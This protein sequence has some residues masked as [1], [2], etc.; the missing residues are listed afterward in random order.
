[1]PAYNEAGRIEDTI[2]RW[3][4][5]LDALGPAYE[6]VVVDDGSTDGTGDALDALARRHRVVRVIHQVNRGHG[7]AVVAGYHAA[8]GSWVLQVDA[9]D[10]V[11]P[12]PFGAFW[13]ERESWDLQLG[14]RRSRRQ[15]ASRALLS[16]ALGWLVGLLASRRLRDA[17]SPY[18]LHRRS[19][20][21]SLLAVLPPDVF[22]PNAIVSALA[23]ARRLRIGEREVPA[24]G[25]R[26]S[27]SLGGL[28]LLRAA[29]RS[30]ADLVAAVAAERCRRHRPP[31]R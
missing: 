13:Q 28:R 9:D 30:L 18:R 15:R 24:G 7:P 27:R 2:A 4:E 12:A 31:T 23:V 3:L 11:G 22:A 8:R 5:A 6:V 25:G 17:N 26:E 20:L 29:G 21:E 10:E 16:L 14:V 1:V 19:V